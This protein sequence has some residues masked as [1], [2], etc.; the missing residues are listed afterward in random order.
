MA[1]APVAWQLA[2]VDR[3]AGLGRRMPWSSSSSL[4]GV[5]DRLRDLPL[6]GERDG[7]LYSERVALTLPASLVAVQAP[8]GTRV[9]VRLGSLT[10]E[11]G[12]W[13]RL[14]LLG[15]EGEGPDGDEADAAGDGWERMSQPL[16]ASGATAL[17][18]A[19]AG[20]GLEDVEVVLVGQD[21]GDVADAAAIETASMTTTRPRWRRP[22][23]FD[24]P[25]VLPT[26]G[27][28]RIISR[29]EW[30]ANESWRGQPSY[31]RQVRHG[32]VHHTVNG[33]GYSRA[34]GPALVR[35]IYRYHTQTLGWKDIGYNVLVDRYG[36]IY[37]GRF[38]G[39]DRPVI[40]SHARGANTGSF[41]VALIGDFRSAAVPQAARNALLEL[42]VAMFEL[43][44]IDPRAA[45]TANSRRVSTLAGHG[46]VGSTTCP[47]G[48]V[49]NLF[50]GFRDQLRR[51]VNVRFRD[52]AGHPHEAAIERLRRAGV[53]SGYPDGTFR[54]DAAVDRGQ[55]ATFITRAA[56]LP[57]GRGTGFRDVPRRHPHHDGIQSVATAG[58]AEGHPD[59]TFRPSRDVTRAQMAAF[60]ARALGLRDRV[61]L[62]F[63]DVLPNHP[64]WG[65]IE[66]VAHAGVANG[67]GNR[68]FRPERAVTRGEMAAFLVR[69]FLS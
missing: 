44:G 8:P 60:L 23:D 34:D 15:D 62:T 14:P 63:N 49:R 2:S 41:G 13:H 6:L 47:G 43:H 30:G 50:P 64:H 36:R 66:A 61:G 59:G 65:A 32:L 45:V 5:D 48:Q 11:L 31:A 21:T 22:E 69:A 57:P 51:R 18:V 7:W 35:S 10:G 56:R 55:M 4:S 19:V 29:R 1:V 16:W 9:T 52:I 67:Y 17:Q 54:P 27:G 24:E 39:L 12:S 25:E 26:V 28:L 68:R 33:N 53:T 3:L 37:E 40:G 38:G 20:A 58:I 42:L 46:D